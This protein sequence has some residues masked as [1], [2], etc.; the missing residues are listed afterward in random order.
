MPKEIKQFDFPIITLRRED[1]E[2][3]GFDGSKLNDET[4]RVL[5]E[6]LGEGYWELMIDELEQLAADFN[7][8]KLS[9]S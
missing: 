2:L 4:M 8:P 6:K 7:V 9:Q 5:A 1:L 3:I